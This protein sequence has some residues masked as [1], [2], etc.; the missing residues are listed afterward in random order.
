MHPHTALSV[1]HNSSCAVSHVLFVCV[2]TTTII[3]QDLALVWLAA[4]SP[5]TSTQ[6]LASGGSREHEAT[7]D[8]WRRR[9]C[10]CVYVCTRNHPSLSYCLCYC[11]CITRSL[12]CTHN[13]LSVTVPRPEYSSRRAPPCSHTPRTASTTWRWSIDGSGFLSVSTS[14]SPYP[15]M[16]QAS[17]VSASISM[18]RTRRM[19]QSIYAHS[20]HA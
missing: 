12:I 13:M 18:L 20:L 8:A 7:L 16:P 4:R 2:Y 15:P 11:T 10:V 19:W 6:L 1:S 5:G 9:V 14:M 3:A 17:V